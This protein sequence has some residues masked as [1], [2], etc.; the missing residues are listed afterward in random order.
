MGEI[1]AEKRKYKL[2][3][4]KIE[5]SVLAGYFPIF[6]STIKAVSF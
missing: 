1:C 6:F 3:N 2:I 4:F 5:I